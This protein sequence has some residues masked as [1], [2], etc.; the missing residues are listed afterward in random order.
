M[1]TASEMV[2]SFFYIFSNEICKE[3][4]N[5]K[6]KQTSVKL[7]DSG[8]LQA[9]GWSLPNTPTSPPKE[10]ENTRRTTVPVPVYCGPV[11]DT[12]PC[13]KVGFN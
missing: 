8:R 2:F 10:I 1:K 13:M 12:E 7:L 9:C 5:K 6:D 3:T 4:K 11:F